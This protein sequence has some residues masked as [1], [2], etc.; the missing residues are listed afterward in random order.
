MN[1]WVCYLILAGD[2]VALFGVECASMDTFTDGSVN[3]SLLSMF[4]PNPVMSL[5]VK[6][7]DGNRGV[8]TT[9]TTNYLIY[10]YYYYHYYLIY[11]HYHYY[12]HYYYYYYHH[13]Y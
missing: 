3:Y 13:H 7:K 5:S 1:V 9:T 6:P 2:V 11:Y 4:V 12:Y 8:T 10:Y